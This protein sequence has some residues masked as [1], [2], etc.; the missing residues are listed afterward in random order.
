[1]SK[2][3]VSSVKVGSKS[4]SYSGWSLVCPDICFA[5]RS[6][7]SHEEQ[8]VDLAVEL[9]LVSRNVLIRSY[10]S[11]IVFQ[12]GNGCNSLHYRRYKSFTLRFP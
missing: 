2:L 4:A 12:M 6:Y 1:M 7:L 11:C 5:H 9:N 10:L 8:T 3:S